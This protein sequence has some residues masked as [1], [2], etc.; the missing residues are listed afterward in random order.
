MDAARLITSLQAFPAT[1]RAAVRE[2]SSE[3]FRWKPSTGDWSVLEIIC[4]LADEEV[5]DFRPRVL[6]TLEDPACQWEPIDPEGAAIKNRYLEQ[7]P[8]EQLDRF[9]A[10]R[11]KS[12]ELLHG[13]DA[14]D[15]SR[16]YEH[17]SIGPLRA[18]DLLVS[19]AAHDMLH[20]RQITKRRFEQIREAGGEFTTKYAGSW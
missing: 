14:P 8:I 10:E 1:L 17:P 4:H 7:D 13:I 16:A 12:I 6:G 15:W 5:S 20:L 11:K 9:C 18:G 2:L 3:A 19:W